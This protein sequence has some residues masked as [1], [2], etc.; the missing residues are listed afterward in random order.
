MDTEIKETFKGI[1]NLANT[2]ASILEDGKISII[3]LPALAIASSGIPSL[4][5]NGKKSLKTFK[6]MTPSKAKELAV[7]FENEYD[8]T[9][10]E[11]E[12]QVEDGI[13][14]LSSTYETG[15]ASFNLY[16]GWEAWIANFKNLRRA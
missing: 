12:K 8:I 14:L 3:E 5:E 11:I 7:Y 6:K 4:V 16:K 2:L 10:D 1:I 13:H 9:N 15:L